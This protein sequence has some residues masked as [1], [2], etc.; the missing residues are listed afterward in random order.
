MDR[1]VPVTLGSRPWPYLESSFILFLPGSDI[2]IEAFLARAKR[3]CWTLCRT[4]CCILGEDRLKTLLAWAKDLKTL[5]PLCKGKE[6][7]GVE[8]CGPDI[9]RLVQEALEK[10]SLKE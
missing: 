2:Y 1:V 9:S 8:V 4:R 6:I 3:D 7:T 5:L 10:T